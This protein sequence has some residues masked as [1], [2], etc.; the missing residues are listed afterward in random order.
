MPFT[1]EYVRLREEL[2]HK[3]ARLKIPIAVILPGTCC[4][5]HSSNTGLRVQSN[6]GRLLSFHWI[7]RAFNWKSSPPYNVETASWTQLITERRAKL[8]TQRFS[9]SGPGCYLWE[10]KNI[11]ASTATQ[12]PLQ[13]ARFAGTPSAFE[14]V[15]PQ[16][17]NTTAHYNST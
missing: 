16:I 8:V 4:H 5:A 12:T 11:C 13:P 10:N 9:P 6:T 14:S 1:T 3:R 17:K 2:L 15:S 7:C